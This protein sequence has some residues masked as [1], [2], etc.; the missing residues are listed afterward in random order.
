[1][2]GGILGWGQGALFG[3]GFVL[4]SFSGA[5]ALKLSKAL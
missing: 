3:W 4:V 1:M 2:L 5:E